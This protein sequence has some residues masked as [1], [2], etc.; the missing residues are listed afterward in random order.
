MTLFEYKARDKFGKLTAGVMEANSRENAG[1]KLKQMGY[2]PIN[3]TIKKREDELSQFFRRFEKVKFS[4]LNMLT[5][6]LVTLQKAGLPLLTSLYAMKDQTNSNILKSSLDSVIKDIEA[7]SLFSD[8]LAKHPRVFSELYVTMVRAGE[9]G[10]ILDE[11]LDRLTVLGE[12]EEQTRVKIKT[13]TRYPVMVVCALAIAF[14]V[15]TM[16]VIPRFAKIFGQFDVSL[17]LPTQILILINHILTK[18]WWLILIMGVSLIFCFNRIL[19]ITAFRLRWDNLRLKIPI[20][21]PLFKNISMS[22]FARIT[23]ILMK[24]GVPILQ[25]LGLASKGVGNIVISRAIDSIRTSVNGG[26][27]I[28]ETMA[29]SGMFPPAVVQMVSAGE[30]TGRTDD[31]LL[32]VS[33]YYDSQVEY[34]IENLTTLIE[35]ILVFALGSCVLFI[36]LGVF[37]PMWNL[38]SLFRT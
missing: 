28:S 6:Q 31:L 19:K 13:A 35:P 20:F 9:T 8:A 5:K 23:G 25:I 37:L 29:V 18:Y 27:R 36:A 21:G 1:F 24:S 26:G 22:R 4:D 33:D 12:R 38:M 14:L 10:G 7:G 30:A 2:V 17:P 16:F 32:H 34:T 15:L 3:I 11:V